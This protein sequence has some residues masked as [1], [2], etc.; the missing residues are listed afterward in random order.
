V[1]KLR[2]SKC[3]AYLE[4]IATVEQQNPSKSD[5]DFVIRV[6]D[7]GDNELI[8]KKVA[9]VSFECSHQRIT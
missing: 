7:P 5:L 3:R 8:G 9:N 4:I 6:G 1:E 2:D